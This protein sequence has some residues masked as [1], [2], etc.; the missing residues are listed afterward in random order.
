MWI[1]TGYGS[2]VNLDKLTQLVVMNVSDNTSNMYNVLAIF[3]NGSTDVLFPELPSEEEA[4][5]L[6]EKILG[7]LLVDY[8]DGVRFL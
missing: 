3:E 2:F 7:K 1:K 8:E 4:T 6:V 5:E